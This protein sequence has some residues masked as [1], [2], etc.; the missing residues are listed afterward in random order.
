MGKL[1]I[2]KRWIFTAAIALLLVTPAG[3]LAES[4]CSSE[5]QSTRTVGEAGQVPLGGAARTMLMTKTKQIPFGSGRGSEQRTYVI[6]AEPDLD[7]SAS[8]LAEASGDLE[9]SDG[10]AIPQELVETSATVSKFGDVRLHVC[11]DASD[12]DRG[13]YVGAIQVGGAGIQ[14]GSQPLEVT[15]REPLWLAIVLALA[16]MLVGLLLKGLADLSKDA[17]AKVQ[18]KWIGPYVGRPAFWSG[19]LLGAVFIGLSLWQLYDLNPTWGSAMDL[20]KIFAA[21]IA[22]QVTGT[23]AVDVVKP[24]KVDADGN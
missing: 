17:E 23:T 4:T 24:F 10:E 1:R 12:A 22:L 5:L 19:V 15:L 13:R 3:A 14:T 2:G 6:G 11:V 9:T 7:P 16:G 21:G 8:V 18:W 20:F